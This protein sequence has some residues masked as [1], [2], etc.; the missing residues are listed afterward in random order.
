MTILSIT[1]LVIQIKK[2]SNSIPKSPA[3][4]SPKNSQKRIKGKARGP[5][6]IANECSK[7]NSS[8]PKKMFFNYSVSVIQQ[9]QYLISGNY[10]TYKH[11][12]KRKCQKQN[13]DLLEELCI[14]PSLHRTL[15]SLYFLRPCSTCHFLYTVFFYMTT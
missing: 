3:E 15:V 11:Y 7:K 8:Q 9:I 1:G 10:R 14:Y 4:K 13:R 12:K 5:D 6:G 2:Y